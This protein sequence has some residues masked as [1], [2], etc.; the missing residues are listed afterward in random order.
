[1]ST[2]RDWQDLGILIAQDHDLGVD[3]D[4]RLM[5][6]AGR[7]DRLPQPTASGTAEMLIIAEEGGMGTL[8][9][10]HPW[11]FWRSAGVQARGMGMWSMAHSGLTT[12]GGDGGFRH[13]RTGHQIK[14]SGLDPFR[15]ACSVDWRFATKY[16]NWPKCF[17]T[18]PQGTMMMVMPGTAESVQS[19]HM[20]HADPR[21]VAVNTDTPGEA[22]TLVCDIQP[23]GVMCMRGNDDHN[24]GNPPI[25]KEPGIIGRAARLQSMMRVIP[26]GAWS[27][28]GASGT[29]KGNGLAWNCYLAGIDKI[30]GYGMCW[31]K[32]KQGG[33]GQDLPPVITHMHAS[34]G[35][36]PGSG[37]G[38]EANFGGPGIGG[39]GGGGPPTGAAGG[40]SGGPN[41][42]NMFPKKWGTPNWKPPGTFGKP[43]GGPK[44]RDPGLGGG[45][46]GGGGDG[47]RNGDNP[48]EFGAFEEN[49]VGGEGIT[50]MAQ[51]PTGGPLTGGSG[52]QDKHKIGKD[53]DRN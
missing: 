3:H 45:G 23:S 41:I 6:V 22:G 17:N 4:S 35:G 12:V 39:T 30:A 40:P 37:G 53:K 42:G 51:V 31:V 47:P 10:I 43:P 36:G 7:V 32:Y 2:P 9:D 14:V 28:A 49:T 24:P 20:L 13:G 19:E 33:G 1:M 44:G 5:M 26:L 46:G 29:G 16:P 18:I 15:I 27:F 38:E 8:G 34:L 52:S 11:F 48:C 50:C 25:P 21:L